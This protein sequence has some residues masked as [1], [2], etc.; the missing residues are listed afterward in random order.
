MQCKEKVPFPVKGQG[1]FLLFRAQK[2]PCESKE[3]PGTCSSFLCSR[4]HRRFL[5]TAEPKF[6][7]YSQT[8]VFEGLCKGAYPREMTAEGGRQICDT[9]WQPS[10][11]EDNPSRLE[12]CHE[13]RGRLEQV[14]NEIRKMTV[15]SGSVETRLQ[16]LESCHRAFPGDVTQK[17]LHETEEYTALKEKI[18]ELDAKNKELLSKAMSMHKDSEN[19]N[20]PSRLSAVLQMYEMLRLHDWAKFKTDS[21]LT[22]RT[23]RSIIKKLFNAC[24]K[25]I[26][27]R[28]TSIFE[29][30][31]ISPSNDAMTNSK[32]QADIDSRY[33]TPR[34]FK[35]QCC[36]VY[37]LLLLQD[38]PV[39]AAWN[40]QESSMQYLEHVDKKDCELWGKIKFLWPI[41][42]RGEEVIVRGVVW[43]EN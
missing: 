34:Q 22:Y 4:Q 23:G 13:L 31:G 33:A 30:L 35:L 16:F 24:E 32:E 1:L 43:D 36:K 18:K 37:C 21:C 38:P 7:S 28:T 2:S 5:S 19:M 10:S 12:A 25:D 26:E 27:Q 3:A 6:Y 8:R 29:V 17:E 9:Q 20:D 15:W 41:M 42:K 14:E 11:H 39:K 40:L